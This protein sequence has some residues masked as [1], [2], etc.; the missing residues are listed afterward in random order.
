M[1]QA[2]KLS[3]NHSAYDI[4]KYGIAFNAA[5]LVSST[6]EMDYVWLTTNLLIF[7]G[8]II[9]NLVTYNLINTSRISSVAIKNALDDVL[10]FG[11]LY[12]VLRFASGKP[13][14]DT[15]WLCE[16]ANYLLGFVVYNIVLAKFLH[17]NVTLKLTSNPVYINALDNVYKF[18]TVFVLYSW[19]SGKGCTKE[20]CVESAGFI[21]GV[22]LYDTLIKSHM[23]TLFN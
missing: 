15:T 1:N 9:Y 5:H 2:V 16:S 18:T 14:N 3:L 7:M 20:Y 19:L 10:E 13:L 4:V 11:T 17:D 12:L 8:F 22:A 6:P 23:F 21:A